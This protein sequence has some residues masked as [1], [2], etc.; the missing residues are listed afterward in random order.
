MPKGNVHVLGDRWWDKGR[1]PA[2]H[3]L[4]FALPLETPFKPMECYTIKQVA[5]GLGLSYITVHRWVSRG[6]LEA[7]SV[8]HRNYRILGKKVIEFLTRMGAE[9]RG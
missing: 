3:A 1:A 6:E 5:D 9:S 8:G 7:L 4:K 2:K